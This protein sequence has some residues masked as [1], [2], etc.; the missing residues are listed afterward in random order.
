MEEIEKLKTRALDEYLAEDKY[1]QVEDLITACGVNIGC[2]T[3]GILEE[4]YKV[5]GTGKTPTLKPIAQDLQIII[6]HVA[7]IAHC[8]EMEIPELENIEEFVEDEIDIEVQMDATMTALAMQ[9]ISANMVL[10]YFAGVMD[11]DELWDYDAIDASIIDMLAHCL[12][13]CRR[14]KLNFVNV[15]VHGE[16]L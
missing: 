16:N 5:R 10:E 1:T 9:S 8:L 6:Q 14:F 3:A 2:A 7:I 12:A 11:G 15:I 4:V 13:I